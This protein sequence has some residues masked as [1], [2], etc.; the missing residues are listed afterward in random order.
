MTKPLLVSATLPGE[1]SESSHGVFRRLDMFADAMK[2]ASDSFNALF[3]V[4]DRIDT[5]PENTRK[6]EGILRKRW[7]TEVEVI[8]SRRSNVPPPNNIW[9]R[10]LYP[11]TGFHRIPDYRETSGEKQVEALELLLDRDPSYIF[12]HRLKCMPPLL[13]TT[14]NVPPVFFDLDDIEH[15]AF[16]RSIGMPPQWGSKRLMHLQVPALIA[17]EK[18]SLEL[19]T[20]TFVCSAS[21][22]IFLGKF[23][24]A[25]RI[26]VIPNAVGIPAPSPLSASRRL[27]IIGQYKYAPNRIGVE[28]FLDEVWPY[29]ISSTPDAVL[30][31]AGPGSESIRHF[32]HPPPGVEFAGF[33]DDLDALYHSIRLVICPVLSGGGTRIKLIE[34]AAYAK[35]I[36]S[37]SIGAEGLNLQDATHILLRDDPKGM[38]DSC[39][40]LLEDNI[41]AARLGEAARKLA[42]ENFERSAVVTKIAQM[43]PSG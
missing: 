43:F 30:V 37:T 4:P 13:L 33:V 40:T 39:I 27:L 28:F 3:Y 7:N 12:V 23:S 21:D 14:R 2:M 35:P 38:A 32:A 1:P 8:L 36:V 26:E 20:K 25:D 11:A 10:Y 19:A 42:E 9:E 17:G 18:R 41:L 16:R 24:E 6:V 5:G 29:I 31:V 22:K 34:A 15:V